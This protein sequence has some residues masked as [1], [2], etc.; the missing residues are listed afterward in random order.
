MISLLRHIRKSLLGKGETIKYLKYAIG[1]IILVVIGILIAVSIN[2]WNT[3]REKR[4]AELKVYQN[5][6]EQIKIDSIDI[7]GQINYNAFYKSQYSVGI[8][9]IESNDRNKMDSLAKIVGNLTQYSDF[10]RRGNIYENMVNSGDIGLIKNEDIIKGIIDLEESLMYMNRM[11]NIHYEAMMSYAI[12]G[13]KDVIKF[14]TGEVKQPE[15]LYSYEFQNL[16]FLMKKITD[17]KEM[18][19]YEVLEKI[20]ELHELIDVELKTP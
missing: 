5:L 6:K 4:T 1:E 17:E 2:N 14:S 18:V 3:N 20:S 19:Y 11:E 10:D 13:M 12:E 7:T 15:T 16:F 8:E 9:I